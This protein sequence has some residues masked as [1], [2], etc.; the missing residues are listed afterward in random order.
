MSRRKRAPDPAP[1]PAPTPS[2]VVQRVRL[3]DLV[4]DDRNARVHDDANRAAIR[5][6]L[7]D[8]GQVEPLVVQA[9]TRRVI[10]GHGRIGEMRGLGWTEADAVVLDVDDAQAR[11]L[12]LRLNRSA[13]LADWDLDLLGEAISLLDGDD[14]DLS[15]LGWSDGELQRL[16]DATPEETVIG[17]ERIA[18]ANAGANGN[19]NWSDFKGSSNSEFVPLMWGEVRAILPRGLHDAVLA[20]VGESDTRSVLI[21]LLGAA[22][23]WAPSP[24]LPGPDP[25]TVPHATDVAVQ[26]GG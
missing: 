19:H 23:G 13:E 11:K 7:E 16:L 26:P 17:R 15:G 9:L 25:V 24:A 6:S 10:A 20:R 8:H 2:L 14:L 4:L 21:E 22:V 3:D 5:A 12:A 1:A 18:D